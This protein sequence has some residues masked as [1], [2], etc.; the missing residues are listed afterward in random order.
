MTVE[1]HK[2]ASDSAGGHSEST[3][4]IGESIAFRM[5]QRP[6]GSSQDNWDGDSVK[7]KG[8]GLLRYMPW[9]PYRESQQFRHSGRSSRKSA[10]QVPAIAEAE[11]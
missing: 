11:D 1:R 3:V 9:Y 5:D 8:K 6:L 7:H 10:G 2:Y 4:K